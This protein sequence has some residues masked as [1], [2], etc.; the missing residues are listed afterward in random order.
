MNIREIHSKTLLTK[1]SGYLDIGFTHSLN[2]YGGC[3]FACRY[4]YVRELPVQKFK[5]IP[6][7][8]WIDIKK[9]A[10]ELYRKEIGKLRKK[11]HPVHIYMSSATDPYQPI[12]REACITRGL[13]E[14]MMENPPDMLVIQTRSPIV[15]RDMDLLVQLKAKCRLV[16]SMTVETDRE[17]V[18]KIFAPYAPSI[19]MRLNALKRLHQAGIPTQAAISPVLPFTC[20]FPKQLKGIADY[21]WIDTM[22][23]GDGADGKRSSRLK[24]PELFAENE[25][26]EW[27]QQDLHVKVERFFKQH[28]PKDMI[29]VS[30]KEAFL[31]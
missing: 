2:P 9:N 12:E 3:A 5:G 24:M 15:E 11:E 31:K 18:K 29:R 19:K 16:V 7:G 14:E 1:T 23:I 6:W 28:F 20:E 22:T 13:L 25:F 21:I 8:E 27:Y 4:C 26:S 17:D 30:K 10:R